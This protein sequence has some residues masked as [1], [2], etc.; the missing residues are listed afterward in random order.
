MNI[1]P[2]IA[3]HKIPAEGTGGLI[4]TL[5][6]TALFLLSIPAFAPLLAAC[7][8]GGLALA[9]LLHRIAPLPP[10][11]MAGAAPMFLVGLGLALAVS[12]AFS[13]LVAA[14]VAGGL[15]VAYLLNRAT[16]SR[17]PVSI[18]SLAR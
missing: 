9:L 2:G 1:H 10:T 8:L 12:P 4:F 16:L 11:Q 17:R 15:A 13:A 3:I 7:V 6:L 18:R 14:C 5:G